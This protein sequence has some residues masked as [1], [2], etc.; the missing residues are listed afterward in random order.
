ML[1]ETLRGFETGRG[2]PRNQTRH[3]YEAML[4][5]PA[6]G[7]SGEEAR[8]F[9]CYVRNGIFHGTETRNGWVIRREPQ[10]RIV[11]KAAEGYIVNRTMLHAAVRK[12]FEAWIE[13]LREGDE[14]A[15]ENFRRRMDQ[16]IEISGI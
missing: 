7:L 15:R 1:I 5:K 4:T 13:R 3:A 12:A 16:V 9:Y 14:T 8:E 6:F 2:I 11:E 10:Q